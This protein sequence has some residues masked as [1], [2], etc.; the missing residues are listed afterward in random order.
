MKVLFFCT[1]AAILFLYAPYFYYILSGKSTVFE[2]RMQVELHQLL[3]QIKAGTLRNI[4]P[5]IL[6]A[7]LLETTYFISAWSAVGN[8]E[9]RWI[10]L[11]FAGFE[12][13]H[14]VR[15]MYFFQAFMRGRSE[16]DRLI[17]WGLERSTVLVFFAH[18]IIGMVLLVLP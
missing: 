6:F 4:Y 16:A 1:A 11:V 13:F 3:A 5:V 7:V 9:F 14:L 18:A 12:V 10:T 8:M 15:T 17:I 2:N